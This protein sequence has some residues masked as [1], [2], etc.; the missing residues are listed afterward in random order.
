MDK[1]DGNHR[2]DAKYPKLRCLQTFRLLNWFDIWLGVY[3]A[4]HGPQKATKKTFFLR[5]KKITNGSMCE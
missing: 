4:T 1:N 2:K 5:D 3:R